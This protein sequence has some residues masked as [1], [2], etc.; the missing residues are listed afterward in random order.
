VHTKF[1]LQIQLHQN[2][3]FFN[4]SRRKNSGS[5]VDELPYWCWDVDQRLTSRQELHCHSVIM[6]LLFCRT[7]KACKGPK[8]RLSSKCRRLT[9]V[10]NIGG[11]IIDGAHRRSPKA[12]CRGIHDECLSMM[13]MCQLLTGLAQKC[14]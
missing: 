3:N 14:L 9:R 5:Q 8:A 4:K 6:H 11:C 1:Y 10:R 2:D 13:N 7:S 12:T